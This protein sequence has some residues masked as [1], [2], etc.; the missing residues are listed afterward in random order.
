MEPRMDKPGR[1]SYTALDF[2]SWRESGTLG[3]TPRFQRRSVW[4]LPARSFFV[5]TLLR[6]LP[7]PPIYLRVT[8]NDERTRVIREVVD[9]QQRLRAL[10]GF[11]DGEYALSRNVGGP[12]AGKAFSS[13][14]ADEQDSVRQY[15][16]ACE[17]MH[18]ISDGE[19]LEIFARLNTYSVRLN[20]Q[21][22]RNGRYF[23]PFKQTAY[24]LAFEHVEF[25]R[26][27]R[28]F[29]EE[30]FARMLEVEFTSE[31]LIAGL[32][33]LQDKKKSV[34]EFYRKFDNDFDQR[35]KVE[36]QF[37]DTIDVI[38]VA[39]DDSLASSA[40][41]RVP[42]FYTLFTVV[43]HRMFGLPGIDVPS[44]KR[45]LPTVE[46][47]TLRQGVALLSDVLDRAK[48]GEQVPAEFLRFLT[49]A[50]LQTDNIGPRRERFITLYRAAFSS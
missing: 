35:P 46:R 14:T 24:G 41:R 13:L 7:V 6:G 25:W 31:L 32:D 27:Q 3:L 47:Q 36:K 21:E 12:W 42:L 1:S 45:R 50:Q 37:R 17:V 9:G 43:F 11:I 33:G 29:T 40:F 44:P 20:G 28:I 19:V 8:Q 18:G 4:K 34:D 2:M 16:F 15:E 22:L 10:L 39:F 23:G 5:D 38:A 30:S 26:R 48:A 49:A